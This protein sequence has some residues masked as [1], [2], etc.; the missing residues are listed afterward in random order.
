MDW[1]KVLILI[2]SNVGF[3]T[4]LFFLN[5]SVVRSNT[6]DILN[7]INV[8]RKDNLDLIAGIHEEIKDL[9]VRLSTLEERNKK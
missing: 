4:F 6:I 2:V 8:A 7:L 3:V 5:G 9:N 1:V